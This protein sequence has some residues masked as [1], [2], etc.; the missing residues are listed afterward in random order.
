MVTVDRA[1]TAKF[2]K[3]GKR[4]EILVDPDIAY[5]LKDGKIVSLS[6]ML[7]VNIIF[8]DAKKGDRASDSDIMKAFGTNDL[9]KVAEAIVKNGEVP[10]TTE[11]RRKRID[12]KKKQIATFISRFAINPQTRVPHPAERIISAMEQAHVSIDPFKPADQQ[13][14]D[15]MKLIKAIIPISL[16]EITLSVSIPAKYSGR[17]YGI[18]KEFNVHQDKWLNDGTLV[19]RITIPAGLKENIFKRLGALTEGNAQIEEIKK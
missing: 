4:F 13:I 11:F 10:L 3:N 9:E 12:E 17:A 19:A 2:E 6:R 8:N 5:D 14:D 15:A 16:E 7:A 1:I 18:L